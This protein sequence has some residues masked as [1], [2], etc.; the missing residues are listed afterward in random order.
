MA[1]SI[2]D[3][4]ELELLDHVLKENTAAYTA[5]ADLYFALC[6]A[7]P[8]DAGTGATITEVPHASGYVRVLKGGTNQST[9]WNA[10]AARAA[11][12]N[13][14]VTW[15][16]ASGSWGTITHW[17]LLDSI[18]DGAGNM[19]AHGDFS[20][21]VAINSGDTASIADAACSIQAVTGSMSD[22]LA[23]SLLDHMTGRAAFTSPA[24]LS[25]ALATAAIVDADTGALMDEV[26]NANGYARVAL[27]ST[28]FDVAVAGATQNGG[29]AITFPVCVTSGWG[30]VTDMAI[31]DG[32]T[33]DLDEILFFKALDSSVAVDVGDTAEFA[34]DALDVTLD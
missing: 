18:T 20:G 34:I 7:D 16:E 2:S 9:N 33:E 28:T 12:N 25:V 29:N 21:G 6:T 15:P 13:G 26:V 30:T 22:Y 24:I 11:T 3:F 23:N 19:I 1:G 4:L 14:A 32:I 17:A 8:T 27:T 5:P 10:A 31:M